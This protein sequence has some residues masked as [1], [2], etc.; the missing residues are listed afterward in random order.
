[1]RMYGDVTD[2]STAGEHFNAYCIPKGTYTTLWGRVHV[3]A[4]G[5]NAH[6]S[7]AAITDEFSSLRGAIS[8]WQGP[9]H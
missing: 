4:D 1:M 5:L 8:E 3:G 7:L 9:G 6:W 2:V